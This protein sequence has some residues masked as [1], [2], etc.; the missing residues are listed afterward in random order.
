MSFAEVKIL[1]EGDSIVISNGTQPDDL[2]P[3][4]A[5]VFTGQILNGGL[6]SETADPRSILVVDYKRDQC[7]IEDGLDVVV[8][9]EIGKREFLESMNSEPRFTPNDSSRLTDNQPTT[10]AFLSPLHGESVSIKFK[11]IDLPDQSPGLGHK[12]D[13]VDCRCNHRKIIGIANAGNGTISIA[14]GVDTVLLKKPDTYKS[15][16]ALRVTSD[17]NKQTD[18]HEYDWQHTLAVGTSA[19][20]RLQSQLFDFAQVFVSSL[21][22]EECHISEL[23]DFMDL[24]VNEELWCS[25]K[26]GESF[27]ATLGVMAVHPERFA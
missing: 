10:W 22:E 23:C 27:Y 3:D 21:V 5:E 18:E 12:L 14:I 7:H 1:P 25:D 13:A 26:D 24:N 11:G 15:S 8:I 16:I 6:L 9:R 17:N 20:A 2:S 19:M 4:Q